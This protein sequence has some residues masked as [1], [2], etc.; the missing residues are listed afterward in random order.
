MLVGVFG[1]MGSG[2][3]LYMTHYCLKYYCDQG[4]YQSAQSNY[5]IT[6]PDPSRP[7]ALLTHE[8]FKTL[9][10]LTD[11]LV[12]I[13]EAY[14]WLDSRRSAS[15][16]NRDVSYLVLQSR[17][18]GFDILYAA[19]VRSSVDL[20]LR[21][22]SEMWVYC[23]KQENGFHY[24]EIWRSSTIPKIRERFLPRA[25]AEKVFPYFDTREIVVNPLSS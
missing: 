10:N 5:H 2:K 18:R 6:S 20:R 13:D 8:H 14:L 11:A 19:Q 17:K 12:I 1:D 23:E 21:D 7:V 24:T 25:S 15:K 16:A 22:L 3:T 9:E 4:R